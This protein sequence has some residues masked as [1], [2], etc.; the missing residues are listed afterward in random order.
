MDLAT[1]QLHDLAAH[2][3]AEPHAGHVR[4]VA[5]TVRLIEAIEDVPTLLG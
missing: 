4:S 1:V 5:P 2:I 3:Q